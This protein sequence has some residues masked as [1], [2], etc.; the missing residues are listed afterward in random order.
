MTCLNEIVYLFLV[1]DH[2]AF[3]N[4]AIYRPASADLYKSPK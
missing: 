4:G 2:H 3:N 1:C